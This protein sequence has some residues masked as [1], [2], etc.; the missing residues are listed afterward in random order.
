MSS[1]QLSVKNNVIGYRAYELLEITTLVIKITIDKFSSVLYLY[2]LLLSI[3]RAKFE[4]VN[5]IPS[6]IVFSRISTY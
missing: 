5:V 1:L 6:V 3:W 2:I 4:R